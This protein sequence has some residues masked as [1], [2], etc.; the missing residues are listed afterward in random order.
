MSFQFGKDVKLAYYR[1]DKLLLIIGWST[2][3]L[4]FLVLLYGM[5]IGMYDFRVRRVEI[6]LPELPASFDGLRIVQLSDIHLGSWTS[7]EK[8]K[9][10]V[11]IVNSL[12]PDVIFFTGDLLD[13]CTKDVDSFQPILAELYA[14]FG[15]FAIL[16]NHDYGDYVRWPSAADKKQDH[17]DLFNYYKK[18]GW[19]LLLNEN[20]LLIRGKDSIAVIGVENW[21]S[22]GRFQRLADMGK[23]L[24]GVENFHVQLL[25]SHD[26]SHWDRVISQKFR[27]IDVTFSGHTHGFQF[28][29][30]ALGVKWSPAQYLYKE[31]GGLYMM[32]VQGTHPQYLYV[33]RGLG[34]I[35]YPGRVGIFPEITLVTL[36]DSRSRSYLSLQ[37]S[38]T[39]LNTWK[40]I[41]ST[42]GVK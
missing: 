42:S 25:L 39:L 22:T 20:S 11:S 18:L 41:S 29:L 2:G 5:V 31:W 23:A 9:E 12:K 36:H 24:K 27:N 14:P 1:R 33:N 34:S 10:A 38:Q 6:T 21:G 15:I 4:L 28:G 19:K 17:Q 30:E 37:V 32:P 35:G 8:L 16:G 26:P 40:S 3:S 7:K 13:Y